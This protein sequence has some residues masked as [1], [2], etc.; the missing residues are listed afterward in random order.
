[1]G[2]GE[3]ERRSMGEGRHKV[4]KGGGEGGAGSGCGKEEMRGGGGME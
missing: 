1:M 2:G 3:G 4:R